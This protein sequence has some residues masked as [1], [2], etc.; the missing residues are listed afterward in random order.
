MKDDF[1]DFLHSDDKPEPVKES[2]T[3]RGSK[4]NRGAMEL[5]EKIEFLKDRLYDKID[6]CFLQYGLEGLMKIDEAIAN[7]L[8]DYINEKKGIAPKKVAKPVQ[9]MIQRPQVV[10]QAEEV[11]EEVNEQYVNPI[12]A[13][14]SNIDM[15]TLQDDADTSVAMVKEVRDPM[16]K[17]PAPRPTVA[18]APNPVT[19]STFGEDADMLGAI[20]DAV[21]A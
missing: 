8:E 2:K 21:G 3:S 18:A 20:A 9:R 7:G 14:A 1:L 17:A 16:P 10:E 11:E 6:K 5:N 13:M 19:S 12:L 15:G 4:Q